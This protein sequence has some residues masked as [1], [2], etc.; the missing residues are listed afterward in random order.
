M[1]PTVQRC[2][3]SRNEPR[4]SRFFTGVPDDELTVFTKVFELEPAAELEQRMIGMGRG[5]TQAASTE[6]R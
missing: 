3:A 1:W 6:C 4:L 2:S 5:R